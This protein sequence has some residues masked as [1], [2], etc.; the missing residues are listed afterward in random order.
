MYASGHF[1]Y[2]SFVTARAYMTYMLALRLFNA[3]CNGLLATV[4]CSATFPL[5]LMAILQPLK[6]PLDD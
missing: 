1:V 6:F 3:I 2:L 4:S 5:R